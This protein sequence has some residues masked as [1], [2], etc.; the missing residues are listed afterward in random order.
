MNI[1]SWSADN[2]GMVNIIDLSNMLTNNIN[3]YMY[4]GKN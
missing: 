2:N 3:V 1:Y 4:E